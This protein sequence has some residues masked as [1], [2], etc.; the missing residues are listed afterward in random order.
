MVRGLHLG[1]AWRLGDWAAWSL[2]WH[3]AGMWFLALNGAAYLVYGLPTGCFRER[4]LPITPSQLR[5]FALFK[6]SGSTSVSADT[7]VEVGLAKPSR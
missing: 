5:G 1:N 3:L 6:A 2:N 7:V 4:L